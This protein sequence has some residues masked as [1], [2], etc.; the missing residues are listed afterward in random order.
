MMEKGTEIGRILQPQIQC[1]RTGFQA[2]GRSFQPHF[3]SPTTFGRGHMRRSFQKTWTKIVAIFP[4]GSQGNLMEFISISHSAHICFTHL[5]QPALKS[6][7]NSVYHSFIPK[8]VPKDVANDG[9]GRQRAQSRP[10]TATSWCKTYVAHG[11]IGEYRNI[12]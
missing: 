12:V 8:S 11:G 7:S 2:L 6:A 9:A 4:R 10:S 5:L 3:A 1:P